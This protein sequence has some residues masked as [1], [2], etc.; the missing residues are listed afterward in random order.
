MFADKQIAAVINESTLLPGSKVDKGT[1]E[2]F[3][4]KRDEN[5]RMPTPYLPTTQWPPDTSARNCNRNDR[6][7]YRCN[8]SLMLWYKRRIQRE[9]STTI[10][11][12]Q[13]KITTF[14][15]RYSPF[16]S[17]FFS[18]KVPVKPFWFD[19]A[20]SYLYMYI[21]VVTDLFLYYIF[22]IYNFKHAIEQ[23]VY[24]CII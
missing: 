14:A 17:P 8:A 1:V 10:A 23:Y 2:I 13:P 12:W 9:K 16:G 7:N 6:I 5:P 24:G 4:N 11:A 19:V 15:A 3:W 20:L 18:L 21:L 22:Y